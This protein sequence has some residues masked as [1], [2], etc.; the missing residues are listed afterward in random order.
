MVIGDSSNATVGL[1]VEYLDPD[2]VWQLLPL[3][4]SPSTDR[5]ACSV[6]DVIERLR[7]DAR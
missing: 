1:E 3:P 7:R 4:P 2:G 6:A 5:G